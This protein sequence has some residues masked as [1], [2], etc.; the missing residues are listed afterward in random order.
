MSLRWKFSLIAAALAAFAALAAS[1]VGYVA[2]RSQLLDQIDRSVT[3]RALALSHVA[4]DNDDLAGPPVDDGGDLRGSP[5]PGLPRRRGFAPQPD[6]QARSRLFLAQEVRSSGQTVALDR[7][8]L[9][10]DSTDLNLARAVAPEQIRLRD[11][12]LPRGGESVRIATV[13]MP[14]IGAIQ[15]ARSLEETSQTLSDLRTRLLL[16]TLLVIAFAIAV[17]FLLARTATKA[18]EHLTQTAE[19]VA[20][21]GTPEAKIQVSGTDEIGRLGRSLS[22]M[23]ASLAQSQEQ[24]QRFVQ[25]A[26]H[27]LRTP[28]TS[29]RTNISVLDRLDRLSEDDRARLIAD[30]NS[31]ATEMSTLVDELVQLSIGGDEQ[32]GSVDLGRLAQRSVERAQRR[33]GRSITAQI[34]PAVIEGRPRGLER[35][36]SNLL[37]NAV[38]FDSSG[39]PIELKVSQQRIEVSDRGPGIPADQLELVFERF[40]RTVESRN[41]AGSGLG[42]AIVSDVAQAHGGKAYARQRDGGGST[43]GF[44]LSAPSRAR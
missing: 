11:S 4:G 31:E 23:L 32:L 21:S 25:D 20:R 28:L 43:V 36:V 1:S 8:V 24:Q 19:I 12:N 33:S 38:K 42:L 14:G 15:V 39:G 7:V 26:G 17:A 29:L 22:Q 10:V 9:P 5:E 2:T 44:T 41:V 16:I 6:D 18:L 34:E 35:A 37:D 3:D 30:L 40:H 27:E 13:A